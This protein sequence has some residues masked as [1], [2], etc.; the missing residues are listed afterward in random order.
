MLEAFKEFL[1]KMYYEGYAN[2]FEDDNPTAFYSQY[3]EFKINHGG[4]PL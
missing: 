4:L 1:D 3:R 2:E